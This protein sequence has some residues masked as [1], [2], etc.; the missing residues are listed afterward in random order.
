MEDKEEREQKCL[1][2]ELLQGRELAMQLQAHLNLPSC[3]ETREL[4]LQKIQASYDKALSLLNYKAIGTSDTIDPQPQSLPVRDDAA[5]QRYSVKKTHTY[6]LFHAVYVNYVYSCACRKSLARWT[7]QVRVRPGTATEGNLDDGFS[8][9]KYG[10]KDILGAK[11]PRG[12]YRCTHR[13]VQGC[14]ATKQVQ[15]SDDDPTIF[16]VA[17]R[18]RHTCSNNNQEQG[19]STIEP[20]QQQQHIGNQTYPL[21]P[22]YLSLN[23]KVENDVGD[24]NLETGNLSPTSSCPNPMGVMNNG[25]TSVAIESEFTEIIRAATSAMNA[26]T[27]GL[28]FP[29]GNAELDPNFTFDDHGFFS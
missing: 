24:G 19:T 16:D 10:Q 29:F 9:R 7:H 14:L 5:V 20:Y 6:L 8:W 2:N 4:L 25:S 26:P 27:V 28:D 1:I 11:Y 23:R 18:G 13:N 17:Y 22:N 15:R 21:L 3:N 12:Y